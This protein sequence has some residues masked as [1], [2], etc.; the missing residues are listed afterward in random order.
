LYLKIISTGLYL[1]LTEISN[2][3]Y[4]FKYC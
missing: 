2:F 3:P 1:Q 4:N